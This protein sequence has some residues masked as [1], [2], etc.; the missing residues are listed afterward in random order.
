MFNNSL[1]ILVEN[2]ES[3][4]RSCI[5]GG[6]EFFIYLFGKIFRKFFR[7]IE[8]TIMLMVEVDIGEDNGQEGSNKEQLFSHKIF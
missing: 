6:F 2:L 5:V 1:Q 3:V 4:V 7:T 8:D